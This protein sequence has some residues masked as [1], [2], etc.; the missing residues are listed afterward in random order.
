MKKAYI[1]NT[2]LG[3]ILIAEDGNKITEVSLTAGQTDR[4]GNSGQSGLSYQDYEMEETVLIKEAARQLTQYLEGARKDFTVPLQPEG[5]LFQKK[6]WEALRAIPYGETRTYRQ[7]AEAIGSPK[8]CR[9]VGM[10][11]HHNP[12][13]VIIPCHRVIGAD[14][15]LT[16]YAAGLDVKKLLLTMESEIRKK[17]TLN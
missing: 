10:A 8:A 1:Y 12:V 4:C 5:T 14:G 15:S 6:V 16:G 9:A 2:K 17:D 3:K 7:I 13:M 11:N